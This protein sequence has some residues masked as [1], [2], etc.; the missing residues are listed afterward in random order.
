MRIAEYKNGTLVYRDATS[1]ESEQTEREQSEMPVPES[2]VE[3][4]L[5]DLM[6]LVE[7]LTEV[8]ANG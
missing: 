1:V 6:E 4:Q 5:A 8:V 7:A 2:T 3:E